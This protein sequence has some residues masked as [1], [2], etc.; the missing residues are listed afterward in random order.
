[1]KIAILLTGQ[2]R[3]FNMVKYL[4][5]NTLISQYNSDVFLSIDLDNSLQCINKNK[6]TKSNINDANEAIR[7]F[8]P[9][10]VFILENFNPEFNRINKKNP[11]VPQNVK[12]LFEQYYI[13][14]NAYNLMLQHMKKTNTTYDIIIRLRFDQFIWTN[15]TFSI[16]Q[17]INKKVSQIMYNKVNIDKL[18]KLSKGKKIVFGPTLNNN[19]YLLNFGRF[20]NYNYS[21][22]ND[23]FWYHNPHLTNKIYNFYDNLPQLLY[24]SIKENKGN[25]GAL[26]EHLWYRYITTNKINMNKGR[27]KGVFV[28][29]FN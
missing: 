26:I 7:F 29:E 1:M 5:L 25:R 11:F 18:N 3:T 17:N 24:Q 27:V 21:Y 19:I 15:E 12:L 9:K 22:A 20:R 14:K 16:F 8:K 4:H 6:K 2:L 10:G 23:Q 28:R 13:V